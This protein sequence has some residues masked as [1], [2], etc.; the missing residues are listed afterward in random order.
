MGETLKIAMHMLNRVFSKV[1][2]GTPFELWKNRKPSLNHI[3]IWGCL[4][5]Q[6]LNTMKKNKIKNHRT[7]SYCFISFFRKIYRL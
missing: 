3:H 6:G 2:Q 7:I 5:K 1:I 4:I